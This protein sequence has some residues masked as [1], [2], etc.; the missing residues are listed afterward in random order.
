VAEQEP[1]LGVH[2]DA[3]VGQPE[4]DVVDGRDEA[5]HRR[6]PQPPSR[7]GRGQAAP[8]EHLRL[9]DVTEPLG[10][11]QSRRQQQPGQH[12]SLVHSS[13]LPLGDER[14][15]PLPPLLAVAEPQRVAVPLLAPAVGGGSKPHPR[16]AL[17]GGGPRRLAPSVHR[18]QHGPVAGAGGLVPPPDRVGHLH[19]V[20]PVP[21]LAAQRPQPAGR[22]V[23]QH[24]DLAPGR[25]PAHGGTVA[26]S[27]RRPERR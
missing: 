5:E 20:L 24:D 17:M 7:P 23:E 26:A 10:A 14:C 2:G 15:E 22:G 13:R 18:H 27:G 4:A 1:V 3:L 25:T 21:H 12:R 16:P 19:D 6:V 8:A 11:E 9:G